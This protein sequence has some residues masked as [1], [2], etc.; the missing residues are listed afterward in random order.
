MPWDYI[1]V[2]LAG[3]PTSSWPSPRAGAERFGNAGMVRDRLDSLHRG[4]SASYS[5]PE[6]PIA[7]SYGHDGVPIVMS[8]G[9]WGHTNRVKRSRWRRAPTGT[10]AGEIQLDFYLHTTL[11]G[12]FDQAEQARMLGADGHWMHPHGYD[13]SIGYEE[14]DLARR[15]RRAL[16]YAP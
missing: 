10:I 12:A 15:Y 9:C 14:A 16:A 4:V 3:S 11:V 7:N 13:P 5:D 6:E 8:V 2:L 1:E